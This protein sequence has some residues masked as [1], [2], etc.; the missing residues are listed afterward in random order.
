MKPMELLG[1]DWLEPAVFERALEREVAQ[2]LELGG[3]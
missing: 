3:C 2:V 1:A